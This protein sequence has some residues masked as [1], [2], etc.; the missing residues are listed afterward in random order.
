M[1]D[2][3][4]Q[5]PSELRVINSIDIIFNEPR[6]A[7]LNALANLM[8]SGT[9]MVPKHLQQKPADC[10]AIS[11]QAAQW[12][13]SPFAVAQKTHLVNGVLGY[14]AQ[15]VNA[16]IQSSGFIKGRFSYEYKGEGNSLEC[17]VGA[18]PTNETAI[19]WT[20]WLASASVKVKNSPLWL[21]NPRQ[22]MGYLQV[23]NWARLYCPGAILGVYTS[24]EL[25]D[26][27]SEKEINPI[28]KEKR[29]RKPK[30]ET[31]T[32]DGS[33]VE[34][35]V[36]IEEPKTEP[37]VKYW[38]QD[39]FDSKKAK[40]IEDIKLGRVD[41]AKLYSFLTSKGELSIQQEAEVRSWFRDDQDVD[42]W[43]VGE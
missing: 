31:I 8:A 30:G 14:E 29:N 18:I 13:M 1:N 24:D 10:F 4:H 34:S 21:A 16:V 27:S 43:M 41:Q 36:V 38:P 2:L 25:L 6:M 39:V 17:R 12:G 28:S 42:N 20:E 35:E 23:K 5:E 7:Q 40:W 22:Q 9:V 3:I 15:L 26:Q 11:L 33:V 32:S 19:V 37:Q